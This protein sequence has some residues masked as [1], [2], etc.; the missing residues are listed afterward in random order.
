MPITNK[1]GGWGQPCEAKTAAYTVTA[2]DCGKIFTNTGAGGSVTFTLPLHSSEFNGW[3]AEFY[4]T[5]AQAIVIASNP[6]DTLTVHG[7]TAADT[8]TTAATVGQHF[9]VFSDGT[10]FRVVSNPS[11]AS[12]ATAV[13]AVTIAT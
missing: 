2:Y 6:V 3:W 9:K 12:A 8:V 11:A 7:D 5:A 4:T 13:T 1:F 10:G